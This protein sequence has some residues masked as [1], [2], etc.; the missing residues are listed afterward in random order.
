M[1]QAYLKVIAKKASQAIHVLDRF[2]VVQKI[3]KAIDKVRAAEVKQL[4]AGRLR[5][6]TQGRTL[7]VTK[8]S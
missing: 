6:G 7:V 5:R 8:A 1:W 4:K 2:H 3:G